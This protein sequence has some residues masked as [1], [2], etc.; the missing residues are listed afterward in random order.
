MHR[1]T[2]FALALAGCACWLAP[3]TM[4]R[5]DEPL[6]IYTF[7]AD[8]TPP[9][10]SQLCHGGVG[11]AK[12][13]DDPLSARGLVL[14]GAGKPIVLC[15]VDWTGIGND[16]QV[17]WCSALAEAAGT[18]ADRVAVHAVHVH[19]APGCD[20]SV[21]ELLKP[22]GLSGAMYNHDF[23]V[24]AIERT[25]KALRKA[26]QNPQRF[27]HVG[28]GQAKVEKIASNR[29]IL[30]P[31]GKVKY[32]RMSS[33]QNKKAV[34]AP[35]GV[36][37]PYVRSL[38]FW[39]GDKPL[40]CLSYYATHPMVSYRDGGISAEFVGIARRLREQALPDVA[41]IY[42][43]GAGGN[44]A[45][46][47]YND[48]SKSNRQ[49]FGRRLAQGMKAAWDATQRTPV[50]AD[51]VAWRI[52]PVA[53]PPRKGLNEKEI[54]A[55]LDD[56][57]VKRLDR[58]RAARDLIW[59]RRCKEGKPIDLTCLRIGP[60]RVLHMPSELFVEYQLAANKMCSDGMVLMAAYGEYAPGYIGTEAAYPRG[61]Y[62]CGR[63]SRVAPN[64]EGVLMAGMRRLLE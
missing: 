55:K 61:G 44:V 17:A 12:R 32:G 1:R 62:E 4:A 31:D 24:R 49:V 23:A 7:Q 20:F 47:K 26:S 34:A 18:T 16:A 28:I 22:R 58:I 29:R 21:E 2:L 13:V 39:D 33:C 8:V 38:S 45:G 64:V 6:Q 46:G 14:L 51:D 3:R 30:G 41:Q 19:S 42:F 48:G 54:L 27:T 52:V 5:A 37:D 11:P 63:A 35:E 15:S 9:I 50:T 59:L 10:G 57:K 40:A 36:I 25:A 43:T 53:L 56:P 60:A